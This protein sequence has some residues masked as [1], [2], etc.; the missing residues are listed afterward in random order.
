MTDDEQEEAT[1]QSAHLQKSHEQ[2][3]PLPRRQVVESVSAE[4]REQ[5]D[6]PV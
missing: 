3:I 6:L 5:Q 4:S 2:R 1:E